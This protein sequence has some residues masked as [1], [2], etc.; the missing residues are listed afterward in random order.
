MA[1]GFFLFSAAAAEL[2]R[3]SVI[4]RQSLFSLL[5]RAFCFVSLMDDLQSP[6]SSSSFSN[7][8]NAIGVLSA[9]LWSRAAAF[10][11]PHVLTTE[12]RALP[13]LASTAPAMRR[14]LQRGPHG[15]TVGYH[16]IRV[17]TTGDANS[18]HD[19]FIIFV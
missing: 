17:I 6:Q 13:A 2:D 19:Y 18:T 1:L 10:L 15:L 16:T 9:D 12:S 3:T 7:C 14:L 11:V 8:E 5:C 4:I